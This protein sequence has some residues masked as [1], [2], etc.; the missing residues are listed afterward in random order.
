MTFDFQTLIITIQKILAWM[1]TVF[2]IIPKLGQTM[3]V[4]SQPKEYYYYLFLHIDTAPAD[5]T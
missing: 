4:Y 5:Q 2:T 3:F 1:K